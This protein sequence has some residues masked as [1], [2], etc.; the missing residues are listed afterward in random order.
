MPRLEFY[1][2]FHEI[3]GFGLHEGSSV[4]TVESYVFWF[5]CALYGNEGPEFT[6]DSG[7]ALHGFSL[8]Y[9]RTS[10]AYRGESIIY[11]TYDYNN[12][13]YEYYN[14]ANYYFYCELSVH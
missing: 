7:D 14:I 11:E 9:W 10:A 3:D 5:L 2:I 12:G 8:F 13:E 6:Y 4:E 1:G